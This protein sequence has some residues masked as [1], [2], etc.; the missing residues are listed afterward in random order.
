M[1]S[2]LAEVL[3]QDIN[4][5][6]LE[7]FLNQWIDNFECQAAA[8]NQAAQ[9]SLVEKAKRI[10]S[11]DYG[12]DLSLDK[13]AAQL[14]VNPCYLSR[15]FH[16]ETGRKF[17]DYLVDIRIEKA[18]ELLSSPELRIYQVGLC[19]GYP[20]KRYFSELFQRKCGITPSEYRKWVAK[21]IQ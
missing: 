7:S 10:I 20:N 9:M 4:Q 2:I 19:V 6:M 16:K 18:K 14:Y 3:G 15:I 8:R 17:I 1:C 5:E 12:K 13:I 21:S 11:L